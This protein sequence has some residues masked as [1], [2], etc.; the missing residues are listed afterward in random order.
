M[1]R[2]ITLA[3]IVAI[4]VV[5]GAS[6]STVREHV[7]CQRQ[8]HT[9]VDYLAESRSQISYNLAASTDVSPEEWLTRVAPYYALLSSRAERAVALNKSMKGLVL[10]PYCR[11]RVLIPAQLALGLYSEA[12]SLWKQCLQ[13]RRGYCDAVIR[14]Y[15][16]L[17]AFYLDKA[18][19]ASAATR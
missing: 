5:P 8:L 13:V 9:L 14:P 18:V 6:A 10:S 15:W 17:A 7:K 12:Q 2:K 3:I 4:G 11:D 16:V 19:G 1:K